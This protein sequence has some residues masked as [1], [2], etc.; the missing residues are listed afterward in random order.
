MVPGMLLGTQCHLTIPAMLHGKCCCNDIHNNC[1]NI[2][3]MFKHPLNHFLDSHKDLLCLY[4]TAFCSVCSEGNE[5][6]CEVSLLV[7][8]IF[9]YMWYKFKLYKCQIMSNK[10]FHM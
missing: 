2:Y 8:A 3:S 7:C 4:P 10:S 9:L 5:R 1:I 6:V